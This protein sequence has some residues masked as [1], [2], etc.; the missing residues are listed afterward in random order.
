MTNKRMRFCDRKLKYY[1]LDETNNR[2]YDDNDTYLD[3]LVEADLE[4]GTR[5]EKDSEEVRY[6]KMMFSTT[7]KEVTK[8][9]KQKNGKYKD[10]TGDR[11][12]ETSF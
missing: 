11:D 12:W 3:K 2:D 4:V 6:I 10:V 5:K 7:E 8:K 1:R 9:R